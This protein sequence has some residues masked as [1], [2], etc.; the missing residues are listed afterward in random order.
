M[1]RRWWIV[2]RNTDM[3][4]LSPAALTILPMPIP[5]PCSMGVPALAMFIFSGTKPDRSIIM[6]RSNLCTCIVFFV[7]VLKC[8][9]KL[10]ERLNDFSQPWNSQTNGR[11]LVWT[12]MCR[13]KCSNRLKL[14]PQVGYLHGCL[15]AVELDELELVLD[16][17]ELLRCL[18]A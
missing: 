5:T 10:S 15:L 6:L 14:H 8:A 7:C 2:S 11:S 3:P 1:L 12:N 17:I 18:S 4:S 13:F 9:E 16:E